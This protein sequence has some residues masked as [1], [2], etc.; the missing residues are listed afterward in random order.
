[1]VMLLNFK[2]LFGGLIFWQFFYFSSKK[3]PAKYQCFT[4]LSIDHTGLILRKPVFGV[5]YCCLFVCLLYV[6]V[7]SDG[8]EGRSVHL[9]TLFPGQ[10]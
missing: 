4:V 3:I 5:S 7:N 10:A 1:M 8:H 2:T 6:P 9:T